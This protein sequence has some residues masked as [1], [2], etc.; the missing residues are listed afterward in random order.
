[1]KSIY[2]LLLLSL[3]LALISNLSAEETKF[4][5][6]LFKSGTLVYSDD[7]DGEFNRER[8][9]SPG[10]SQVVK[11]G[12]LTC[13]PKFKTKE[14]AMK[15]L[16]R[17]HHLGLGVVTHLNKIPKKFVLHMRFKFVTDAIVPGR[18]SFQ[19]GH[20]MMSLSYNKEGGY[21]LSLPGEERKGFTEPKAEMNI[22]E[23]VDLIIEYQEGK[24]LLSVNGTSKIYEHE[25]VTMDNKKD[26]SGPRFSFKS[27]EGTEERI[28]FDSVRLWEVKE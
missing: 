19:I 24:M 14:E 27:K 20:H 13:S 4:K 21:A 16:K 7:F 10:K 11:D 8:W 9:G 2:R 25:Q 26:K 3:F 23:W 6:E 22:N 28:M 17:D 18:P 5:S 12:V 15:A 1:M